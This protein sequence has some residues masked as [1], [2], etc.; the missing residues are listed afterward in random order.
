MRNRLPAKRH[1]IIDFIIDNKANNTCD[2]GTCA[3]I[4]TYYK[5]IKNSSHR[6]TIKYSSYNQNVSLKIVNYI[7]SFFFEVIFS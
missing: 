1:N 4:T 2:I 6:K 5:K 3:I 7:H